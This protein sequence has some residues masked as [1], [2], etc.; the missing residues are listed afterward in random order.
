MKDK[1]KILIEFLKFKDNFAKVIN[2][3]AVSKLGNNIEFQKKYGKL[4]DELIYF[5]SIFLPHLKFD[6]GCNNCYLDRFFELTQISKI[7]L[8]EKINCTAKIKE[9]ILIQFEG[10]FYSSKS[11]HITNEIAEKLYKVRPDAFE[12]YDKDW[13]KKEIPLENFEKKI[14]KETLKEFFDITEKKSKKEKVKEAEPQ[15][16]PTP[17]TE[18]KVTAKN[19]VKK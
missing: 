2:S 10:K 3:V 14:T 9:G 4:Y 15:P 1:I 13:R 8:M 11:A 16:Q 18:K 6:R 17:Q 12:Y 19:K 5:Y 7:K